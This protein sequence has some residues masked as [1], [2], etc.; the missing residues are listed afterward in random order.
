M[1][2]HSTSYWYPPLPKI[3]PVPATLLRDSD[4]QRAATA[5]AA[6]VEKVWSRTTEATLARATKDAGAT[7][8]AAPID[9]PRPVKLTTITIGHSHGR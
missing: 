1:T 8:N 2:M 7:W 6:S 3:S 4:D 5:F 9:N